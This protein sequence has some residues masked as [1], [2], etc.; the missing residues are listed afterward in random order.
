MLAFRLEIV[1]GSKLNWRN[2]KLTTP[3]KNTTFLPHDQTTYHFK[4]KNSQRRKTRLH[5]LWN[6]PSA[7]QSIRFQRVPIGVRGM[8]NCL[9]RDSGN[10]RIFHRS[11]GK[12][13]K[14][15]NV[16]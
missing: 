4:L 5:D 1:F 16:F 11:S 10:G 14:D 8:Q 12:G 3:F 15:L 7:R 13:K 2:F 6:P 9:P